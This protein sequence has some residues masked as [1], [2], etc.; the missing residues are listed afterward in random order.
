VLASGGGL[1]R[2]ALVEIER[3]DT[4]RVA[5]PGLELLRQRRCAGFSARLLAA[6]GELFAL[7]QV[8]G[9]TKADAQSAN[10]TRRR[11]STAVSVAAPTEPQRRIRRSAE[12][13]RAPSQMTNEGL[14]RPPSGGFTGTQSDIPRSREVKG[15]A[16]VI[17]AG[18]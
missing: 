8:F 4:D 5:N 3:I 10:S 2:G 11:S 14:L 13:D 17:R 9:D 15:A 6:V 1:P 18:P 7:E 12:I 16:T